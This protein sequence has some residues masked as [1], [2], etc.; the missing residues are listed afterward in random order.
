MAG[1]R[2]PFESDTFWQENR[3]N[4]M[5]MA[6]KRIGKTITGHFRYCLHTCTE[7]VNKTKKDES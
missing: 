4:S 6:R 3:D 1:S 7:K 2:S 5:L